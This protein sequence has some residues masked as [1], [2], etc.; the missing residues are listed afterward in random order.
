MLAGLLVIGY[1]I[2]E[3][4]YRKQQ[5]LEAAQAQV[6]ADKPFDPMAG[7]F[8]VPPL[9]GQAPPAFTPRRPRV[10][11]VGAAGEASQAASDEIEAGDPHV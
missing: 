3:V 10:A 8:P 6:E 9:P 1:I 2:S 5:R 11:L 4:S 7:G